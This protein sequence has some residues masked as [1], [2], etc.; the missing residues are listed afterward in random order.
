LLCASAGVAL[1]HFG[2]GEEGIWG[3]LPFALPFLVLLFYIAGFKSILFNKFLN[4][5]PVFLVG[6]M[7]YSIYLY[8]G[9]M[10]DPLNRATR[11]L[12]LHNLP[13]WANLPILFALHAAVVLAFCIVMFKLIERPC[14]KRDWPTRLWRRFFPA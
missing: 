9:L 14:M 5:R 6:G 4:A 12:Y 3:N 11:S 1:V 8:H 7:C 10:L 2:G 13:L